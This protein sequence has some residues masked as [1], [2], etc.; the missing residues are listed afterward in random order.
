MKLELELNHENESFDLASVVD[1]AGQKSR[2]LA[3]R[4]EVK[5]DRIPS[6]LRHLRVESHLLGASLRALRR[7]A[8]VR[9][10]N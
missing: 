9:P 1:P 7:P 10:A 4:I 2:S 8:V 6:T 5:R 3:N